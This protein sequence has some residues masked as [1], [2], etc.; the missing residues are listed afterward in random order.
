[1]TR[2][3]TNGAIKQAGRAAQ[4]LVRLAPPDGNH[5]T[6]EVMRSVIKKNPE[7][8]RL[9]AI[10]AGLAKVCLNGHHQNGQQQSGQSSSDARATIIG[11]CSALHGEG[12]TTTSASLSTALAIRGG[13][14]V[15][16][17][18]GD[19]QTPTLAGD[20]G[21][22]GGPGLVECL[23]GEASDAAVIRRSTIERLS[24]LTAGRPTATPLPLL[25][26]PGLRQLISSLRSR[27]AFIVVDM[28]PVLERPE[29]AL[30]LELL[31]KVILVV[32]AGRASPDIIEEAVASIGREKLMGVVL[33]R[34]H[35]SA[36]HWLTR[37]VSQEAPSPAA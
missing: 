30:L 12:K 1:M 2:D 36:P 10:L 32:Q 11:V 13:V 9:D 24:I 28:P 19:L 33:N 7:F 25:A 3:G 21:R 22:E 26:Q 29:S 34:S 31:D 16:L 18:E 23:Q 4:R 37:I 20:L 6:P 14:D 35:S 5:I 27:F 8:H 17:I 15:L